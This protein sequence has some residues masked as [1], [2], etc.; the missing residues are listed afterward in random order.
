MEGHGFP[1]IDCE[2]IKGG[3][4]SHNW[5]VQALGHVLLL[6]SKNANLDDTLQNISSFT[7]YR[8]NA[9]VANGVPNHSELEPAHGVAEPGRNAT[10]M[11]PWCPV[12]AAKVLNRRP[13]VYPSLAKDSDG[14]Y[15]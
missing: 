8:L 10:G 13:C 6:A 9:V 3:G 12:V 7:L 4:L 1:Y 15:Q 14:Y 11:R 5:K 2:F